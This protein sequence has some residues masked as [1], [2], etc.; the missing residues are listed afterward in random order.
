MRRVWAIVLMVMGMAAGQ[1]FARESDVEAKLLADVT[2]VQADRPFT[3]AVMVTPQAGWHVYWKNPGDSG[4]PTKI[5][6]TAPAGFVVGEVGYPVPERIVVPGNL[7]NYGYERAA[8]FLVTVT[9]PHEL[10]AGGEVNFQVN[11]SWLCCKEECVP[12]KA[13]LALALPVGSSAGANAEVFA[14]AR[15]MMPE[16][17]APGDAVAAVRDD[18]GVLHVQ[19]KGTPGRVEVFPFNVE[20]LEVSGIRVE[21]TGMESVVTLQGHVM[22]GQTLKVEKLQILVSFSDNG[23]RSR[24]FYTNMDLRALSAHASP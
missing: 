13:A 24:G 10:A 12:G 17:S 22:S 21:T 23:G 19:W 2:A 18:N 20:G 9:P 7:V 1:V 11:A 14:K 15:A 5:R 6:V 3:L 4:L 16:A 8:V